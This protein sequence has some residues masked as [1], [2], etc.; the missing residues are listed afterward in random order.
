MGS[1]ARLNPA[2]ADNNNGEYPARAHA[3]MTRIP[4]VLAVEHFVA[5]RHPRTSPLAQHVWARLHELWVHEPI[6]LGLCIFAGALII[7]FLRRM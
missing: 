4:S 2:G 7:V 1:G 6:L 3:M 5:G